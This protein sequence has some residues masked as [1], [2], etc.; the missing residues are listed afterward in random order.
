MSLP[1]AALRDLHRAHALLENPGLTARLSH[2]LGAPIEGAVQRLPRRFRAGAIKASE[3]ALGRAARVAL[4]TLADRP[5]ISTAPLPGRLLVATSGGVGGAFGLA[6]LSVE[7]PVSTTLMLRDIGAI[8]RSEGESPRA[9]ATRLACLQV[10]ALG[11][12]VP[13]DD[14][15][16]SGYYAARLA[17]AKAVTEALQHVGANRVLDASGPALVRL[18]TQVAQR[19]GVQ[20]TQKLAA[21][22][23]PLIGAAGGATVNTLFMQH[24]QQM[25][26]GHFIVRRLERSYGA[27]P[28]RAAYESLGAGMEVPQ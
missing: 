5:G 10:F 6:G 21:Q 13:T 7:L 28:V 11:G 15:A 27:E 1:P 22:T 20:V 8:A 25:A 4:G 19:F 24:F 18:L 2:L 17:L 26:R 12:P 14:A 23:L 9:P 16:E 3:V